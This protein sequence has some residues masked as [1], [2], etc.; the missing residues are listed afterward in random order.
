MALTRARTSG[1]SAGTHRFR[2]SSANTVGAVLTTRHSLLI[3]IG[4]TEEPSPITACTMPREACHF[5]LSG[6][7]PVPVQDVLVGRL[8]I[9]EEAMFEQ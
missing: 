6:R 3:L 7:G 1:A 8:E 5:P 9:Q 2:D 4:V